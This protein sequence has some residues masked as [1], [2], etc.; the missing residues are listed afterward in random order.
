[1][2][3]YMHCSYQHGPADI[4]HCVFPFCLSMYVCMMFFQKSNC[5]VESLRLK[6]NNETLF[7]H[8]L[9]SLVLT[10]TPLYMS[11]KRETRSLQ[12]RDFFRGGSSGINMANTRP[13]LFLWWPSRESRPTYITV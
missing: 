5:F 13:P 10:D 6:K 11:Y 3:I 4:L 2:C 8:P 1:M 7:Y 12:G 9:A